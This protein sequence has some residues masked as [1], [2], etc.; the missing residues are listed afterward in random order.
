MSW[1]LDEC[2]R[3]VEATANLISLYSRSTFCAAPRDR[4][5]RVHSSQSGCRCNFRHSPVTHPP[6]HLACIERARIARRTVKEV[7][8]QISSTPSVSLLRID[9]RPFCDSASPLLL[10]REQLLMDLLD[11]VELLRQGRADLIPEG[12]VADYL[13]LRWLESSD[14]RLC[15]TE[16]GREVCS[17]LRPELA[18]LAS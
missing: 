11:V 9:R 1:S 4:D 12:Y 14:G 8:M 16:A 18:E 6:E 2:R 15:L 10:R 5:D 13:A 3:L 17:R 7:Q